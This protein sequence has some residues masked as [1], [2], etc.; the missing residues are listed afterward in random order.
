MSEE[1]PDKSEDNPY[2]NNPLH[3]VGLEA[4]LKELVGYYGFDIL[5]AYLNIKCFKLNPSISASVKFLKKT[6]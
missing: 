5:N 2:L 6:A 1:R 3:G 4:I